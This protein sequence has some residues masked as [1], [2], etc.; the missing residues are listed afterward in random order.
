[1]RDDQVPDLRK[2][3]TIDIYMMGSP[4]V[5][6]GMPVGAAI[7]A[8]IVWLVHTFIVPADQWGATPVA[9]ALFSL[10]AG[11]ALHGTMAFIRAR[12][13]VRRLRAQGGAKEAL[14]AQD[15]MRAL[16]E[17]EGW[18]VRDGAAPEAE[19]DRE[20]VERTGELGTLDFGLVLE[21]GPVVLVEGW[22]QDGE[23]GPVV[24]GFVEDRRAR[25]TGRLSM[26]AVRAIVAELGPTS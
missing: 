9:V 4:G 22:R 6:I 18:T 21:R 15:H 5:W 11:L 25:R 20:R 2:P 17:A 13:A 8:A 12:G 14:E 23:E 10:L 26:E 16:A 24:W 3:S 19:A 7:V 1:M